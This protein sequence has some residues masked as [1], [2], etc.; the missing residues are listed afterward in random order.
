MVGIKPKEKVSRKWSPELAYAV[1]LLAADGC[2]SKDGRHIDLT[3]NDIEQLKNFM[4]C[5]GLKNKIGE[6]NSGSKEKAGKRVQFGDVVF[7]NF[8]VD[9]GFAPAK[10][11]TIGELRIPKK[12]FFDF[13]RGSFDGDGCFYS[14]FDPRWKSSFMFY[15]VFISASKKHIDWLQREIEE[16]LNIK[17]HIT[18]DGKG[19]TFQL[20]YAK[21]ESLELLPSMY[22]SSSVIC[23][24]RKRNK[25]KKALTVVGGRL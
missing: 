22:Y 3:S 20:K 25:I 8:L 6:K 15:T 10:S 2:L 19:S 16:R 13:L 12:Y 5:L 7:Y 4:M 21:T 24:S 14:Y 11:K 23:L 17:G 1:G 9:I 18:K